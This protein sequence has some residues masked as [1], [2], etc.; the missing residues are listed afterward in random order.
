MPPRFI[1]YALLLTLLLWPA[2][3]SEAAYFPS[4]PSCTSQIAIS[5]TAST[6]LKTFTNN[7]YICFV[8]LISATAQNVS[9]VQGTGTTCATSTVAL[10]GATTAANGSALAANAGWVAAIPSGSYLKTTTTAQ[11]LCLLQDGTGR[12]AGFLLYL[13]AP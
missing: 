9:L 1:A 12:I 11:H 7:G 13:D 5:Q 10:D 3:I 4:G 6:D 8:K 2:V